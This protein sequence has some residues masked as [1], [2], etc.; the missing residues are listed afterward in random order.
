MKIVCSLRF[1]FWKITGIDDFFILIKENL[2]QQFS[3]SKNNLK[4]G[5]GDFFE[6]K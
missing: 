1:C 5:I 4:I 3:N 6:V 2:V